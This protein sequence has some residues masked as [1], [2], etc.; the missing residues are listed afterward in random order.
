MASYQYVYVMKGLN[1]TYPGGRQVLKDIW[2]T[3]RDLRLPVEAVVRRVFCS[4]RGGA[5]RPPRAVR[6]TASRA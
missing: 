4:R 3:D 2:N 1:K 5:N 6:A